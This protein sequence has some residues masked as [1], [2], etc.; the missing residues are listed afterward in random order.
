MADLDSST[1]SQNEPLAGKDWEGKVRETF[2]RLYV[3]ED[4]TLPEVM[5]AMEL[6]G[7]RATYGPP[8][9]LDPPGIAGAIMRLLTLQ[10]NVNTSEKSQP[11][12]LTRRSKTTRCEQCCA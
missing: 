12:A 3:K 9:L 6:L 5:K 4:N 1:A 11:G 10:G 2:Y 7:F 8:V